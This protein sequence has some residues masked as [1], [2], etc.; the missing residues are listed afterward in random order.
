MKKIK[1][2]EKQMSMI[3][4]FVQNESDETPEPITEGFGDER[5]RR[6][7]V[8]V[9]LYYSG[10][11]FKGLEIGNIECNDIPMTFLIDQEHRSWG[12]KGISI[13]DV[14]GVDDE[15]EIQVNYWDGV[16]DDYDNQDDYVILKL[17][18][19]DLIVNVREGEGVVTIDDD[20]EITLE[21]DSEGNIVVKS[22]EID[23]LTL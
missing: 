20:I 8:N 22:M 17:N 21:N 3:N 11:K 2:T 13:Y 10:V 4:E 15:I 23:A 1:L 12:I 14:R 16:D 19:D 9:S 6:D 5:Y 18:W 7:K